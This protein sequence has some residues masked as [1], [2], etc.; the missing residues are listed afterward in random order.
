M[1]VQTAA[2]APRQRFGHREIERK[3]DETEAMSS[4]RNFL[5]DLRNLAELHGIAS[6]CIVPKAVPGRHP[7]IL[8]L[9]RLHCRFE[10]RKGLADAVKKFSCGNLAEL[11]L[12]VVQIIDIHAFDA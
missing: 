8:D 9:A 4:S 10:K 7:V 2:R 5:R 1:T 11:C 12:R 6:A 3:L